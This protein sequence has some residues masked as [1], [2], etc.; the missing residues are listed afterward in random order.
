MSVR[1][2]LSKRWMI[3]VICSLLLLF[4]ACDMAGGSSSSS[5]QSLVE[6]QT[7]L[8]VQMTVVAMNAN[9]VQQDQNQSAQQTQ[10]AQSAQ[11]TVLAV[12]SMQATEDAKKAPAPAEGDQSASNQQPA[13]NGQAQSGGN[14]PT[15]NFDTWMKS[16]SILLYEDMAGMFD[17]NRIILEALNGLGLKPNKDDKDSSGYFLG[18]IRSGGPS[19]KPWDLIISGSEAR[20]AI[21]GEFIPPI[22]EAIAN[23]SALIM[24][25]WNIDSINRGKIA[26]LLT[27][28]GVSYQRD[29][30]LER[31]YPACLV[32]ADEGFLV[33]WPID[34]G[35]PILHEPNDGLRI[36][37]MSGYWSDWYRAQCILGAWSA[38]WDYGDA[39]QLTPGS[40]AKIVLGTKSTETDRHGVLVTC[41]DGRVTLWTSS[42]HN[43]EYE[44]VMPLWQN[45]I[46]NAL[47][48]RFTYASGQ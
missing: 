44:R 19:G 39:L 15:G 43:Y 10:I 31:D 6:T 4:L 9:N 3:L 1:D 17:T 48:A 38:P 35:N 16:A 45:M 11:A 26:S 36:S 27:S 28:C 5:N 29:I 13:D 14:A 33:L 7:A 24:E 32:P 20:T 41:H 46:Y 37:S 21:Q 30:F 18:D 40:K 42:T 8:N 12:Q 34:T 2:S 23:G 22:N 47:K 25:Q